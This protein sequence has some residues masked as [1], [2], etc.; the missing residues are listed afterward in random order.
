VYGVNIVL[1]RGQIGMGVYLFARSADPKPLADRIFRSIQ[2]AKTD[3][4]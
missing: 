4:N 3:T 1:E 2:F